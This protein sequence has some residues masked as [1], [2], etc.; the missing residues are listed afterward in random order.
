MKIS[1]KGFIYHKDAESFED[2]FDRYGVNIET[3]KFCVS[4]G[5][6][7]SFFP[8]LWA[9]LLVNSFLTADEN[10]KLD[11]PSTLKFIQKQWIN[12]VQE[13]V[14]KPNQKYF[15][16]NFFAQGRTAAAT[17]VGL[18]FYQENSHFI[19]ESFALGDSFLF[20]VPKSVSNITQNFNQ[21]TYLSSKRNFEFDNFPDFFDSSNPISKGKIKQ[22]KKELT[23]GTF[24]LMTDALSEWFISEKQNAIQE[25][26]GWN[27]QHDYERRV[28]NLRNGPLHDDDSAILIIDVV[29]DSQSQLNY[30]KVN[31]SQLDKLISSKTRFN[32]EYSDK[33]TE[34]SQKFEPKA[35]TNKSAHQ[36]LQGNTNSHNEAFENKKKTSKKRKFWERRLN[37]FADLIDFLSLHSSKKDNQNKKNL[38]TAVIQKEQTEK[39]NKTFDEAATDRDSSHEDLNSI[40][41]KF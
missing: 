1:V 23:E 7:K 16:R 12:K 31:I 20:F 3:N 9:E 41:D 14:D 6:S 32:S 11:N 17:F 24:Y 22:I 30:E 36:N 18:K 5:V 38:P 2:C 40:T 25:I 34:I 28:L 35:I 10:I 26:R 15:V 39:K 33:I 21:I 13:I 19:W 37:D 29:Q 27:N 4:D 8:G